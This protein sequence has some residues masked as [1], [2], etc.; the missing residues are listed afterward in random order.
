DWSSDVCSSDLTESNPNSSATTRFSISS[1]TKR[2]SS[3]V[4]PRW[5]ANPVAKPTCIAS[6]PLS[7]GR[8]RSR[9]RSRELDDTAGAVVRQFRSRQAAPHVLGARPNKNLEGVPVQQTE[10]SI[11]ANREHSR[12]R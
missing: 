4:L 2:A 11:H 9:L 5:C 1:R 8:D 10:A 3:Y 7:R 12:G 6:H